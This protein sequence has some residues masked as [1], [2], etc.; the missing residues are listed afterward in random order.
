MPLIVPVSGEAPHSEPAIVKPAHGPVDAT[1]TNSIFPVK[2]PAV[3]L[4][5]K[6]VPVATKLYHT[7][8]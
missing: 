4:I 7:S 5:F 2:L 3:T 8:G 1:R 6:E